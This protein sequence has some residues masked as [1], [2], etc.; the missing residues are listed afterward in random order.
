MLQQVVD[1]CDTWSLD[2]ATLRLQTQ[3]LHVPRNP[4]GKCVRCYRPV[5]GVQLAVG[6]AG[7]F[8]EVVAPSKAIQ[9]AQQLQHR[10]CQLGRPTTITV[11]NA[12]KRIAW[13]GASPCPRSLRTQSWTF[14]DMLRGFSGAALTCLTTVGDRVFLL[15]GLPIGGLLSKT[16]ACVT[17]GG[18][19]RRWCSDKE[20]QFRLGF[21]A[22][23]GWKSFVC[24]LRYTDDVLL[25]S[26]WYCGKC[27]QA[28][29]PL[30]YEDIKFDVSFPI[31]ARHA[32]LDLLIVES[33]S[34]LG[35]NIKPFPAPPPWGAHKTFLRS[36]LLGKFRRWKIVKPTLL[37]WQRAAISLIFDLK[38]A[39][40]S[41][42]RLK[43]VL[44]FIGAPEF[45]QFV[46]FMIH[47]L[48]HIF[49]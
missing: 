39:Q 1:S 11:K 21:V 23:S 17:L 27:L 2:D 37:S 38:Q 10:A 34:V 47:S 46:H 31:G 44:F 42:G 13:F 41:K 29:F 25:A 6:D 32:W 28:V 22:P 35:L 14:S 19:E 36:V 26:Y 3:F 9:E 18:Y 7:Q 43:Q 48:K 8:F 45:L 5:C 33:T 4:G 24:H 49:A 15:K 16:A 30:I 40:W 12:S 20:R